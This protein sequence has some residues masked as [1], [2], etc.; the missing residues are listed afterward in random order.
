MRELLLRLEFID[1]ER[2]PAFTGGD[3]LTS[4][5]GESHFQ[6]LEQTILGDGKPVLILEDDVDVELLFNPKIDIPEGA[7]CVYLGISHGDRTYGARDMGHGWLQVH[8]IFSTHAILHLNRKYSEDMIQIGRKW[9]EDGK[10]F[11]VGLAYEL[12]GKYRVCTPDE[13]LFFQSNSRNKANKWELITRT[14]LVCNA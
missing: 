13:P 6:L 14:P 7:D 1:H 5:C 4:S 9:N 10:P 11:D 12:Q 3:D 8:R 2:F